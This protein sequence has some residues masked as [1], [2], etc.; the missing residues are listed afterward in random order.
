MTLKQRQATGPER[1]PHERRVVCLDP[2]IRRFQTYIDP[3]NGTHGAVLDGYAWIDHHNQVLRQSTV[4][5]EIRRRCR[6]IDKLKQKVSDAAH[7]RQRRDLDGPPVGRQGR[8]MAFRYANGVMP[9]REYQRFRA[10]QAHQARRHTRRLLGRCQ[11]HLNH[12]KRDMHYAACG[13][14]WGQWDTVVIPTTSFGRMCRRFGRGNKRRRPFPSATARKAMNWAHYEFRQRLK[15]STWRRVGKR[16][17][18]TTEEYTTKTCGLCG[19][20]NDHVGGSETFRCVN[21]A[22]GITIDRDVNGARNIGLL[23]MTKRLAL[24]ATPSH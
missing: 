19:H 16:V 6:Q 15:S 11:V 20:I 14:L 3:Q 8:R 7:W 4:G 10:M 12:F 1:N 5:D 17:I 22:C 2:G 23:F 18:E 13:F 24:T 21:P 9:R